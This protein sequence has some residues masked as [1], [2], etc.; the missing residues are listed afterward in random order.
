LLVL[1]LSQTIAGLPTGHVH[2]LR[3]GPGRHCRRTARRARFGGTD[4]T[5]SIAASTSWTNVNI[6]GIAVCNGQCQVSVTASGQT[7]L[8][9]DFVL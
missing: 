3:L 8:I 4:K 7:V 1:R 6:T 5:T 2:P 9:D